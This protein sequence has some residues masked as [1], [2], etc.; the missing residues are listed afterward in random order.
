MRPTI[1][2]KLPQAIVLF[3]NGRIVRVDPLTGQNL[4]LTR[5]PG[6]FAPGYSTISIDGDMV[7][8]GTNGHLIALDIEDGRELWVNELKG[9]GYGLVNVVTDRGTIDN[10]AVVA[11]ECASSSS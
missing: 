4:W 9:L 6:R 1:N 10:G 11:A 7:L 3:L 2:L 8:V 5:V